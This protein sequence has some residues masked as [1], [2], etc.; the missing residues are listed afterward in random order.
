MRQSFEVILQSFIVSMTF[1]RHLFCCVSQG[2][3]Q[4]S[5]AYTSKSLKALFIM[6]GRSSSDLPSWLQCSR[7]SSTV[8]RISWILDMTVFQVDLQT[9][10][11]YNQIKGQNIMI[12]DHIH[13]RFSRLPQVLSRWHRGMAPSVSRMPPHSRQRQPIGPRLWRSRQASF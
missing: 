2:I 10:T 5:N 12:C 9:S 11:S 4:W 1:K 6:S 8:I 3:C 7:K 13:R